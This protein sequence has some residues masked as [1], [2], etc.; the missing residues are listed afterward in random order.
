MRT[1]PII[2][3]GLPAP[4][5]RFR[6]PVLR[7]R[8]SAILLALAT[9]P[10]S[11]VGWFAVAD[12]SDAR[13][14]RAQAESVDAAVARLAL[15]SELKSRLQDERNWSA[16]TTAIMTIGVPPD[17][18][19]QMSGVDIP[20]EQNMAVA[21]VDRLVVTLGLDDVARQLAVARST[22]APD[23]TLFAIGRDYD[24]IS[25]DVATRGQL[26][27]DD[28]TETAGQM[29]NGEDLIRTPRVLEAAT[30]AQGWASRWRSRAAWYR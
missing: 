16:A 11:G 19:T 22:P 26:V 5:R 24:V 7:Y 13:A 20:G 8:I 28:L 15:L 21:D 14:A 25:A 12:V 30:T 17:V 1:P 27:I 23:G 18:S 3:T 6:R 4:G 2:T 29:R 9:L 10:L